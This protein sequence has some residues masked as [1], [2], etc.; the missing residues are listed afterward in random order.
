MLLPVSR[1]NALYGM[2]DKLGRDILFNCLVPS[3][4][5]NGP[6]R[7]A[8]LR[9]LGVDIGPGASLRAGSW[10]AGCNA[11]HNVSIG[12]GTR[13]N[14]H[15]Y[16]GGWA[17]ITIGANCNFGPQVSIH[18][19][20]HDLEGPERRCGPESNKAVTI[21][22]G[23]WLGMRT[24]VLPGVT[25]GDGCVIAAGAVVAADCEPNGL[26]GGVPARRIRDL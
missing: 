22:T 5:L 11:T 25:I 23:C 2:V 17:P 21:G 4:L 14:T 1:F 26:Y 15:C 13:I 20:A 3:V 12:A 24:L 16:F 8:L 6:M 10:F 19:S 9:R 18:T 7:V